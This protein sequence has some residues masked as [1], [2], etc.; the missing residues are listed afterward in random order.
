MRRNAVCRSSSEASYLI[1]EQTT[2]LPFQKIKMTGL[3]ILIGKIDI[4]AYA[5][6]F[7]KTVVDYAIEF[8]NYGFLKFLVE[9][10]YIT[11]VKPD[12]S[13]QELDLEQALH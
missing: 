10:G 6:E 9:Q 12:E 2:I 7:G 3:I 5:D 11:L 8:K 13:M 4:A 1:E